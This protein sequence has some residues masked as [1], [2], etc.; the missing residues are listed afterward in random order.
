MSGYNY[1]KT[2]CELSWEKENRAKDEIMKL[3]QE[4]ESVEKK[5]EQKYLEGYRDAIKQLRKIGDNSI[6]SDWSHSR[7]LKFA[8]VELSDRLVVEYNKIYNKHKEKYETNKD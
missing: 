8:P 2:E 7:D 4:L 3:E 5:L 1:W 6:L